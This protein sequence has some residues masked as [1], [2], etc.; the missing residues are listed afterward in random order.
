MPFKL[1]VAKRIQNALIVNNVTFVIRR[2]MTNATQGL[3]ATNFAHAVTHHSYD[4]NHA[5]CLFQPLIPHCEHGHF[6][7]ITDAGC[8][9]YRW[10][11]CVFVHL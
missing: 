4:F 8:Q 9:E 6:E 5:F 3:S 7:M 2:P 1:M 10:S 11:T